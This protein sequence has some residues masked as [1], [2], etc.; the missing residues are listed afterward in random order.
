[1]QKHHAGAC[2]LPNVFDW[3]FAVDFLDMIGMIGVIGYVGAYLTLQLGLIKGDGY[4][5]PSVN[6]E[7]DARL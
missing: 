5:F 1:L 2:R 6:R 3:V 7:P 4:L